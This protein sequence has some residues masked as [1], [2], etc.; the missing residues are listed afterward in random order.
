MITETPTCLDSS[1]PTHT[2]R[3]GFACN[4][5]SGNFDYAPNPNNTCLRYIN[6][7]GTSIYDCC[8]LTDTVCCFGTYSTNQPTYRPTLSPCY[9]GCEKKYYMDTCNWF[10]KRDIEKTCLDDQNGDFRCC[11]SNRAHC[12]LNDDSKVYMTISVSTIII[13]LLCVLFHFKYKIIHREPDKIHIKIYPD[14]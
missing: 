2:R 9:Q 5:R 11:T 7:I 13:A 12:C 4:Y 8:K 10:E 3:Y 6:N 1:C 14:V